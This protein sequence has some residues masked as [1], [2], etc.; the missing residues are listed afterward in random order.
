[1]AK[2]SPFIQDGIPQDLSTMN[3][4]SPEEYLNRG[5]IYYS[6][7]EFSEAQNDI[8]KA[9]SV[10]PDLPDGNF[11]L[12]LVLKASQKHQEA[13]NAF[14][15]VLQSTF[16]MEDTVKAGMLRRLIHGHIN[17]I[18]SGDWNLEKEIWQ[19]RT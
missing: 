7:G 8:Q 16:Q 11:A 6:R 4:A 19:V 18:Q 17:H 15:D 12:A 14:Q 2:K 3:P 10:Q 9:L 1:M 13:I 5:W